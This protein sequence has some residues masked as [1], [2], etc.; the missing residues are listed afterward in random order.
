MRNIR[1]STGGIWNDKSFSDV[2]NAQNIYDL[3]VAQ[4]EA[5]II[6]KERVEQLAE[7]NRL[8]EQELKE[9]QRQAYEQRQ[10]LQQMS[11]TQNAMIAKL[12][13]EQQQTQRQQAL[14]EIFKNLKISYQELELLE[15]WLNK[16]DFDDTQ[17]LEKID[18]TQKRIKNLSYSHADCNA[19]TKLFEARSKRS[20]LVSSYK[21]NNVIIFA[22]A[23]IAGIISIPI[24]TLSAGL[25]GVLIVWAVF[26]YILFIRNIKHCKQ[27]HKLDEEIKHRNLT[28]DKSIAK[29][30]QYNNIQ[31]N[32]L[33]KELQELQEQLKQINEENKQHI[34]DRW[35]DFLN[36]RLS[37]YNDDVERAIQL[38]KI[39]L[40]GLAKTEVTSEGTEQDYI[41]YIRQKLSE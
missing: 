18:Y 36:F 35:Q 26:C 40:G 38:S 34:L 17:I 16:Q 37:H 8:K 24:A 2:Q 25:V 28:V 20:D 41:D 6:A 9:Q 3:G 19:A 7:S 10:A 31:K 13:L 4:E 23:I 1:P 30:E 22:I 32:K 39:P 14:I 15:K 5:N 27:L 29:S 21:I 33:N 11:D 12:I